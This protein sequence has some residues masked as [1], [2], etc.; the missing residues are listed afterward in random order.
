MLRVIFYHNWFRRQFR[1]EAEGVRSEKGEQTIACKLLKT[2]LS[3]TFGEKKVLGLV[4]TMNFL[5]EYEKFQA[6][7]ILKACQRLISHVRLVPH[8]YLSYE[9]ANDSILS[10]YVEIE[11]KDGK[12]FT[13][14]ETTILKNGLKNELGLSIEQLSHKLFMPH[15]EEEVLRNTL[16]LSQE[17]RTQKDPPQ[18]IVN[19]RSQ[20][21][22][23]LTFHVILVRA[24]KE[25]EGPSIEKQF[26]LSSDFLTFVPGSK[27]IVGNLRNKIH[28][29]ANTFLLE[30]PKA[31]FLRQDHSVDLLRAREFIISST[32]KIIGEVRDF[33]GGLIGQQNQL[34]K[35]L[36]DLLTQR[37]M[38][39]ELHLENLFHSI[40]PILR[41]SLLNPELIR[42]LFHLFVKLSDESEDESLELRFKEARL[43]H[44]L[45]LMVAAE[46]KSVLDELSAATS[47]LNLKELELAATSFKVGATYY[48]GF[49]LV[50]QDSE[51]IARFSKLIHDRLT[52]WGKLKNVGQT[53]KISL[54]RPTTL[55]DPR[56]GTDRTSG[57]VIKMLYEGLV[58][59]DSNGKPS[60]AVAERIDISSDQRRYTFHLRPTKW[61]SG[62]AV[63]AYDF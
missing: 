46:E 21:D 36:K 23:T 27:K 8:S 31:P 34:L 51:M 24:I 61:S 58:R 3:F 15:N 50:P 53:L 43:E 49:I 13:L 38:K 30:C 54:P 32:R 19:F 1:H 56:I 12:D 10:F 63:T 7:H 47:E 62:K 40:T 33:N 55:L 9:T 25:N 6:K 48:Q 20:S 52:L 2:S 45:T 14:E 22:D 26:A 17:I 11:K 35:S 42:S 41:K 4:I 37:E 57:I 5:R 59:I 28:K 18:I 44:A 16:L 29:E 39:H 60:L